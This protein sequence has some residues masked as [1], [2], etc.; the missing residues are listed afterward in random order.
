MAEIRRESLFQVR[1]GGGCRTGCL[2]DTAAGK[3]FPKALRGRLRTAHPLGG[4]GQGR[5]RKPSEDE[6]TTGRNSACENIYR[7]DRILTLGRVLKIDMITQ[8]G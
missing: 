3:A 4:R 7:E 6:G 5:G 1:E 8:H 2:P